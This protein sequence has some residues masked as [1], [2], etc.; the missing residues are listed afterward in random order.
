MAY[1]PTNWQDG[2]IITAEK[3]NKIENGIA[4]GGSGDEYDLTII[5]HVNGGNYT[6]ELQGKPFDELWEKVSNY[7]PIT[8][9]NI[10]KW[11]DTSFDIDINNSCAINYQAQ[12]FYN[13][14]EIV[15][16]HIQCGT[17]HL[18]ENYLSTDGANYVPY[19]Y[20]ASTKKY[21]FSG[22]YTEVN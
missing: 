14:E 7:I 12:I 5:A 6:Y 1:T 10:D 2:D 15:T 19:T 11:S 20:D 17:L 4:T 13:D 21:H 18:A 16:K 22:E 9:F 3:M 8:M